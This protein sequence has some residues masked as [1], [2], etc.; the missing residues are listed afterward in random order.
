MAVG[1]TDVEQIGRLFFPV[2]RLGHVDLAV[3]R[4]LHGEFVA[5]IAIWIKLEKQWKFKT[6]L[7]LRRQNG[8]EGRKEETTE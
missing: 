3:A 2:E 6:A 7:A 5:D 1:D 8:Q 4:R